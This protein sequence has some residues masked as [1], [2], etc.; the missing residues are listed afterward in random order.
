MPAVLV[1]ALIGTAWQ[2]RATDAAADIPLAVPTTPPGVPVVT[3]LLSVRRIPLFLQAPEADRRLVADLNQVVR[4]LPD[5]TCIAVTEYGRLLYGHNEIRPMIPASTQKLILALAA[6]EAMGPEHVFSTRLMARTQPVDGVVDGD[7]WLV[8]GGDPVLMTGDYVERFDDAMAFSDL[9]RLAEKV[10]AAGITTITGAVIGDESHFDSLRY[11]A[12]WPERFRP[13]QQNQAG[14]LSALSVN[15]GFVWWHAENTANGLNTPAADPAEFAAVFFDDLLEDRDLVIKR[16][17]QS[18][19]APLDAVVELARLDSPTLADIVTQ[20]L[21]TSDNTTAELLLKS[22][23]AIAAQPGSSAGGAEVVLGALVSAGLDSVG[24][25]T[26]DGSGLDPSNR[27]TCQV[28]TAVLEDAEHGEELVA[29]LAVAGQSGTMRRR[30]VGSSAEGRARA[31]TGTL[32][33]VTS[34]A[35]QVET[36]EGRTLSFAILTNAEP[37]PDKVKRLHDQVVLNLISYPSGPDLDLL[38]PLIATG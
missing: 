19:V 8:G 38:E 11:V 26:A 37:L 32:R 17:A 30:L 35:G 20:M 28:L 3:P 23:G 33:D 29:G 9:E 24:L 31:K 5:N 21:V 13:G 18:G 34:L 6:L 25:V 7:I 2:V 27:V 16:S 1:L 10:S 14:P 15:D 4:D 36:L 12:T 22:M